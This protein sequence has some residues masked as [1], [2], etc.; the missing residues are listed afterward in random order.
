[1]PWLLEAAIIVQ[2]F[3]GERLEASVIARL[4]VLNAFLGSLQEARARRALALLQQQLRILARVYRDRVWK[5]AP[6]EEL[7]IGDLIHLRQGGIVPADVKLTT[8]SLLVDQS[9]LTGESAAVSV[10]PGKTAYTGSMVRGG[11]ASGEVVATGSRTFFGK[12]AELVR[13]ARSAHRQ[14]HEIT[15]VARNLFAVNGAMMIVVI[16]YAHLAGMTIAYVLPLLLTILLAS[17]PVA[18]L[19]MFTLTAALGC[20]PGCAL[21]CQRSTPKGGASPLAPCGDRRGRT[22]RL[23]KGQRLNNARS[24]HLSP[25]SRAAHR[26]A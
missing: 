14:E 12:T 1:V 25:G 5:N 11:E 16:G 7:A 17:I 3:L 18:L 8:G 24:C 23:C 15:A 20:R 2:L 4:L 26:I 6:A 21:S 13:T 10:E 22:I 19:A 9:A